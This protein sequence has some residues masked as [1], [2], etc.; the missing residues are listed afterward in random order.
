M[1]VYIYMCKYMRIYTYSY[2]YTYMCMYI[3]QTYMYITIY[4]YIYMH[5]IINM[6][7]HVY[8]FWHKRHTCMVENRISRPFGQTVSSQSLLP[9]Q[10][11]NWGFQF[12]ID[13]RWFGRLCTNKWGCNSSLRGSGSRSVWF[14]PGNCLGKTLNQNLE[15]ALKFLVWPGLTWS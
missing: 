11:K 3:Y 12:T 2:M 13:T 8:I 1:Y 7:L 14:L 4:L 9:P 5:I 10:E 6:Y 15:T